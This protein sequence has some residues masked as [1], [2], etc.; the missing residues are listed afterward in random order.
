MACCP[1]VECKRR[2]ST[3]P[4]PCCH[5][6]KPGPY[7]WPSNGCPPPQACLPPKCC[8]PPPP[9]PPLICRPRPPPPPRPRPVCM[10]ECQLPPPTVPIRCPTTKMKPPASRVQF[11]IR[12]EC[13]CC[14]YA[15][16]YFS[17]RPVCSP[18]CC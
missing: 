11:C 6:P 17:D 18:D 16:C 15:P 3:L 10:P 2:I 8:C 1:P 12:N 4:P 9:C 13:G 7:V 14:T 5:G